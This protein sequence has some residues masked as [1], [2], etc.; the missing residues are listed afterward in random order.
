M[1]MPL[2]REEFTVKIR[3]T[4]L[5]LHC[6]QVIVHE[7]TWWS[8][9]STVIPFAHTWLPHFEEM[10]SMKLSPLC[11]HAGKLVRLSSL[12]IV[13][14][15]DSNISLRI[16]CSQFHFSLILVRQSETKMPQIS[17][18]STRAWFHHKIKQKVP[19]STRFSWFYW[20]AGREIDVGV[21]KEKPIQS[22]SPRYQAHHK[23]INIL[24][25]IL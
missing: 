19:P 16:F 17:D 22:L 23:D 10:E 20:L 13:S 9:A 5:S 3:S 25:Y 14:M 1:L 7:N 21:D 8:A 2:W 6:I 24:R 18:V 4:S 12:V 15:K 11:P